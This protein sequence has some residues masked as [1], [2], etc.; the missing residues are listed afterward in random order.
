[1]DGA[2]A[3]GADDSKIGKGGFLRGCRT[4]DWGSVVNLKYLR[5]KMSWVR[6]TFHQSACFAT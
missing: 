1:M 3:V 6:Q 4:S 5:L 2:V